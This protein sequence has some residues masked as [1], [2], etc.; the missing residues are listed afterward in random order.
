MATV[1][2]VV[3]WLI[4]VVG[5]IAITLSLLSV[6]L[7]GLGGCLGGELVDRMGVGVHEGARLNSPS[8]L[9]RGPARR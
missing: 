9:S 8:S 1:L 3:S 2:L 7:L 5:V 4:R 6:I